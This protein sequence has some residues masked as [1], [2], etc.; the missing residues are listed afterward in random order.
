MD[1]ALILAV[2]LVAL[3]VIGLLFVLSRRKTAHTKEVQRGKAEE[4]RNLAQVAQMQADHQAAEAEER[5]ARARKEHLE[6][7][8]QA[9]EAERAQAEAA[10]LHAKADKID[11]GRGRRR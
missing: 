4:H 5:A 6:A 2:A 9:L 1:V 11:P 3:I 8:Q 7:E 10:D